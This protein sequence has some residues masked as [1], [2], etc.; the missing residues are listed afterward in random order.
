MGKSIVCQHLRRDLFGQRVAI[1][2]GYPHHLRIAPELESVGEWMS[3]RV[4]RRN[5]WI[6]A[7]EEP[8]DRSTESVRQQLHLANL[9][10]DH[11]RA[12]IGGVERGLTVTGHAVAERPDRMRRRRR[13]HGAQ[14]QPAAKP[15]CRVHHLIAP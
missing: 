6:R 2:M 13:D 15:E 8:L 12:G 1:R 4:D 10:D 7:L 14:Q 11:D 3:V 9:I 5:D